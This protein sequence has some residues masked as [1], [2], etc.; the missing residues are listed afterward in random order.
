MED[1]LNSAE[2]LQTSGDVASIAALLRSTDVVLVPALLGAE[3]EILYLLFRNVGGL[4]ASFSIRYPTEMELQIEHW[5]DKGEPSE[6]EL[7][8]HMIVD[9]GIFVVTPKSM[10]LMPGEA[11]KV[12]ICMRHV[13][14]DDYELPLLLQIVSGKQVVLNLRGRTLAPA[15][16]YLHL[17][18]RDVH[19]EPTP[20]GLGRPVYHTVDLP[21]FA[22]IELEYE[23]VLDEMFA[24]NTSNFEFP[25]VLCDN[26]SGRIPAHGVARIVLRF[27]PLEAREYAFTIPVVIMGGGRRVLVVRATGYHP[28]NAVGCTKHMVA[29]QKLLPPTQQMHLVNQSVRMSVDRAVFGQ[30]PQGATCQQLLILANTSTTACDFEWDTQHPRWG[31]LFHVYPSRGSLAVGAHR[32]CKLSF[33]SSGLRLQAV[34]CGIRCGVKPRPQQAAQEDAMLDGMLPADTDL[35]DVVLRRESVTSCKPKLRGA[36]ALEAAERR[37]HFWGMTRKQTTTS[38]GEDIGMQLEQPACHPSLMFSIRGCV[39]PAEFCSSIPGQL[40]GFYLPQAAPALPAL[41]NTHDTKTAPSS[42]SASKEITVLNKVKTEVI[43]AILASAICTVLQHGE[44]RHGDIRHVLEHDKGEQDP[45]FVQWIEQEILLPEQRSLAS[46]MTA[47]TEADERWDVSI[48]QGNAARQPA[49]IRST[50]KDVQHQSIRSSAEVQDLVAHVLE[51]TLFNLACESSHGEFHLDSVPR[52]I[53][54][55]LD[56]RPTTS[57]HTVPPNRAHL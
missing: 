55:S 41:R 34:S 4:T 24:M 31:S 18:Q 25:V 43:E 17:P 27:Q 8:Q 16:R 40:Q 2:G 56:I 50:S 52:Q 57:S 10:T 47:V 29:L 20:I 44:I 9:R 38:T 51:G 15:D 1:Q 49:S 36:L 13:R 53:V 28:Q 23:L 39:L 5:A 30:V 19:L 33:I 46:S 22:D 32:C 42:R 7:K 37:L 12:T 48:Q 26:P 21:N 3:E 54:T 11:A 35:E 14:A 6:S 45:F